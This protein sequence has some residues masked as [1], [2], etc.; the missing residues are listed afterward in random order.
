MLLVNH[1]KRC[2]RCAKNG[3]P[4]KASDGDCPLFGSKSVKEIPKEEPK[5]DH[6]SQVKQEAEVDRDSSSVEQEGSA[7]DWV[8]AVKQDPDARHHSAIKDDADYD[9]V[10]AT[11]KSEPGT[12]C[13]H[14][15]EKQHDISNA[16][17]AVP[18]ARRS[19]RITRYQAKTHEEP[20]AEHKVSIKAEV[21]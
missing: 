7:G 12:N 4:R 16:D 3:K 21:N 18:T 2:P 11:V 6:D 17:E 5:S 14:S 20:A 10:I 9:G 8:T 15:Q 13:E 19:S 1:G